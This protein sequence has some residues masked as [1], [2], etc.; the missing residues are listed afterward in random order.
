MNTTLFKSCFQA[1]LNQSILKAASAIRYTVA[2]EAPSDEKALFSRSKAQGLVIWSGASDRTIFN[3]ASVNWAFRALHDAFHLRVG[4][5]FSPDQ[6]IE[7]GKLQAKSV[8]CPYL[9]AIIECEVSAQA[10]FYKNTGHFVPD[11][12]AFTKT[13]LEKQSLFKGL[14]L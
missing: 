7:L 9:S 11:Q 13:I 5:G 3:D 10:E 12:I 1:H 2:D 4:L 14:L 8:T 6:E